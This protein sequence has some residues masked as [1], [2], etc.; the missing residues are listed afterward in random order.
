[1]K[2]FA[3]AAVTICLLS[4]CS[5][6]VTGGRPLPSAGAQVCQRDFSA[7]IYVDIQLQESDSGRALS[8]PLCDVV[9]L[10]LG[11][12]YGP[13]QVSDLAVL[14]TL[15]KPSMAGFRLWLLAR[16]TGIATVS[17]TGPSATWKVSVTVIP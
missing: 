1:M 16:Q 7:G 14:E 5:S 13:T 17:A 2:P 9:E 10:H 3:A 8:V 4:A 11:A 12:G 6:G 15:Q